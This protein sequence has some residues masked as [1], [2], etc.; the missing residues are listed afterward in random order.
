MSRLVFVNDDLVEVVPLQYQGVFDPV[1]DLS[2]FGWYV[3][4]CWS[5]VKVDFVDDSFLMMV[6]P[7]ILLD[8]SCRVC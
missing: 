5:S 4:F 7:S 8:L 3:L 6:V 1:E 2:A